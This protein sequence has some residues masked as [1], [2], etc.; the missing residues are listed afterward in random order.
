MSDESE[1]VRTKISGRL[2]LLAQEGSC[3]VMLDAGSCKPNATAK[4]IKGALHAEEL[5]RIRAAAYKQGFD[6]CQ[7]KLAAEAAALKVQLD[8]AREKVPAALNSYLAD[9]ETQMRVEIVEL[10]FKAAGAIVGS[11]IE[12][13]DIT[14]AAIHSAL[15]PLISP[16]GVKIHVSP[17][18]LAKGAHAAPGGATFIPDPKLK[19]G[20]IMVDSQ[21][22]I[23]DGSVNSRLETLKEE[24][25]KGLAKERSDA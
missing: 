11:E 23:I 5:E 25:M 18:F 4:D 14:M 17:S 16:S 15:A 24:L 21:Q 3:R 2:T 12:R 10:A 19:T 20:E 13:T 22:G 1:V 6:D 7:R 9:L 8:E